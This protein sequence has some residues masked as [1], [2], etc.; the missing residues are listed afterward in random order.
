MRDL[1][2][3]LNSLVNIDRNSLVA[4]L[5]SEA[6]AAK[7]LVNSARDELLRNVPSDTRR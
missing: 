6:E 5:A 1:D 2:A 4:I 7:R 3:L